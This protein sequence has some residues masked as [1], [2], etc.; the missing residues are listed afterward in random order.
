M[1][2]RKFE[3]RLF[4]T[5]MIGSTMIVVGSLLLIILSI[6]FKGLPALSLEM[7]ISTPSGGYYLGEGGGILN[8]IVGSL[9]VSLG[10][11]VLA[12]LISL[13]IVLYLNVF[14]RRQSKFSLLVRF[15]LDLLWGIPSIVYGAFGFTLML[16]FR[17]PASLLA[18]T[19]TLAL[20][21]MP[22][23]ARAMDEVLKM[24]PEELAE[25]AYSLGANRT[26]AAL[27][28]VVRQS[29]PGLLTAVLIA[30]G[31][32][33][34]DAAAVLFTAS[35]TD[36]L[37]YSLFKPVATLPLAIFFQLGTPFPQVQAR[38]YAAALVLMLIVLGVSITARLAAG[39]YSRNIIK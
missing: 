34:G 2:R 28:V 10:A 8:A 26:E 38:G 7:L 36:S 30:F 19:I 6:L 1:D 11:T 37:P 14:R 4:I 23:M 22:I 17:F 24:V 32:G 12:A 31:R 33:I 18:G 27:R 29:L 5:L 16:F 13:P 25:A 35:F 20:V 39:R 3:E 9:V 21:I 15:F